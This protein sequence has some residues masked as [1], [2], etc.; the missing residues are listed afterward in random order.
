MFNA[1]FL[2]DDNNRVV[3]TQLSQDQQSYINASFIEASFLFVFLEFDN[4]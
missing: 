1:F 3:L 2:I 4:L